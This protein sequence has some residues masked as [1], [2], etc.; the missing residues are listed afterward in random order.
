MN[1]K[2]SASAQRVQSALQS[3]GVSCKV[4]ELEQSTR[5]ADEAARAVGCHVGQIV[6]SLIFRTKE[7][8]QPLLLVVSGA[9][10]VDEKKLRQIAGEKIGRADAAF[11]REQTGFAI[12]GIPPVGHLQAIKTFIDEDLMR[13]QEIWAAAGTPNALFSLTPA[14]LLHI[15]AGLVADI[16]EQIEPIAACTPSCTNSP[17][18]P[19]T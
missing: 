1:Q 10:R 4:L 5:S 2:L 14:E 17:P 11:V 8:N 12:G 18:Q 19:L 13:H 7:S 16:K 6:K 9:N 3:N 15:T